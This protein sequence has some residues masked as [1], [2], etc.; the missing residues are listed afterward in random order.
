MWD[1]ASLDDLYLFQSLQPGVMESSAKN[2]IVHTG[3]KVAKVRWKPMPPGSIG[4]SNT[5]A[6]GSYEDQVCTN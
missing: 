6:M 2:T 1:G 5:L 4:K 3:Y